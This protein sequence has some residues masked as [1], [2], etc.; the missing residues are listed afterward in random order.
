MYALKYAEIN[1]KILY[2][3][4]FYFNDLKNKMGSFIGIK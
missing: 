3:L 1:W 2:I 4:K